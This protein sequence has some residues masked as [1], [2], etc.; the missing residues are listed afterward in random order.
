MRSSILKSLKPDIIVEML[1]M[2]VAFENWNKVMERADMLYQCVQSIHEERQEYQSKGMPAP[3]IHI[4]RPL[5]YYYGFSHL[6]RG[7]AHQKMGKVDQA[8][9]C[10]DQ[11]EELG[12]MEELE[13]LDEAGVQVVQEFRYKAQVNRYALEIDAG[14]AEL[15][16]EYVNFLVEHPDEW[17]AG[18]KVITEAAVRHRWQIDRVLH[19][20]ANQ[21]QGVGRGMDSS[22]ND[23]MYRYCYQRALYEQW[24]GRPQEAVEFILQAIRLADRLG[25]D[26]YFIRCTALLESLR[27]EATAEQIGRYR[28]MLE[29]MK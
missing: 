15:L 19:M 24:M 12:L 13:E 25:M 2:A 5:V 10:I 9:A 8:R 7:M 23:D 20:F 11:Y 4:E 21:V 16:E 28:V 1:D 17:L 26:R 18:L 6:M 22:N 27:E 29:E 3:H 14:H